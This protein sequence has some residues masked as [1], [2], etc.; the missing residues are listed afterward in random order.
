MT[1]RQ[2]TMLKKVK[3]SYRR[4]IKKVQTYEGEVY[5]YELKKAIAQLIKKGVSR[6][7]IAKEF[8]MHYT[9]IRNYDLQ[10]NS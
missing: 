3:N 5:P 9:L 1:K 7:K 8:G 6:Y 10:F 2:E 4:Q